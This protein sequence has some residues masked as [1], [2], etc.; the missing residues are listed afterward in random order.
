[1]ISATFLNFV[2]IAVH[3]YSSFVVQVLLEGTCTETACTEEEKKK[4]GKKCQHH[5]CKDDTFQSV[6]G[7]DDMAVEVRYDQCIVNSKF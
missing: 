1:M 6:L 3:F 2:G 5:R 7:F 4:N